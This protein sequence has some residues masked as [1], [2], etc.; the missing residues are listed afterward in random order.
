MKKI[1]I[2]MILLITMKS[3]YHSDISKRDLSVWA[4]LFFSL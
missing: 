2:L 3:K 4:G 1:M